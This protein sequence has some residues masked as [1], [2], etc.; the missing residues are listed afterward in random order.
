MAIYIRVCVSIH[1]CVSIYVCM[2][3]KKDTHAHT[4]TYEE[5]LKNQNNPKFDEFI[6]KIDV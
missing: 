4:H 3:A 6:M 5:K 2:Y 1:I